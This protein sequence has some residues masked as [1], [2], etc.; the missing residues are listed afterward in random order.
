MAH[1]NDKYFVSNFIID[2]SFNY[3]HA[4]YEK[5]PSSF[6]LHFHDAYEML[7]F[8][9]GDSI[10]SVEGNIYSLEKNSLLITNM[11]E[12]HSPLFKSYEDYERINIIFKPSFLSEFVTDKFNPLYP[13]ECRKMGKDN[14]IDPALVEEYGIDK[15]FLQIGDAL[16]SQKSTSEILVKTIMIQM[17]IKISEIIDKSSSTYTTNDKISEIIKYIS[18]NLSEDLSC[19]A[20]SKQVFLSKHYLYH[21]FKEQTGFSLSEYVRNKRI[22]KAKELLIE[23]VSITQL[24]HMIGFSDY[25]TFYRTFKNITGVSP[26]DFLKG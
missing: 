5:A 2:D 10:Y 9:R 21:L 22:I 12:L 1:E 8:I 6:A 17:L 11:R 19:E 13:F 26:K 24:P 25:S 15:M 18:A 20:L 23:G 16:R 4:Y 14:K 7:L 3:T